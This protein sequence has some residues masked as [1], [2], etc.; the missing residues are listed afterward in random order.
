MASVMNASDADDVDTPPVA[1][2][3][4]L[5]EDDVILDGHDSSNEKEYHSSIVNGGGSIQSGMNISPEYY[6][7]LQYFIPSYLSN[8]LS[9][10]SQGHGM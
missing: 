10:A 4:D 1:V 9:R 8:G 2:L 3:D 7:M 6:S 5:F